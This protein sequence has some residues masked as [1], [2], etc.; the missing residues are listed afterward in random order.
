MASTEQQIKDAART[1]FMQQGYA[2]TTT[3]DIAKASGSNV[4]LINYYF[5]SKENLFAEIMVEQVRTFAHG[6][7]SVV[8]DPSTDLREKFVRMADAYLTMFEQQPDTPLFVLTELHRGPQEFLHKIDM[9]GKLKDSVLFKQIKQAMQDGTFN[10]AHPLH[11]FMN[12]LSLLVFPYM[13]KPLLMGV[14]DVSERTFTTLM[15]DR[16]T[17]VPI[18]IDAMFAQR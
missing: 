9:D 18:W 5:R 6:L 4:A 11:V 7:A 10:E 15:R 16:R 2:A 3:R 13:A 1:L 17:L 8:N 14:A 12:L